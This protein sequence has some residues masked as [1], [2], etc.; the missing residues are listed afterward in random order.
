MSCN[1]DK[2]DGTCSFKYM[3][4]SRKYC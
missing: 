1:F 3:L 2:C 4:L